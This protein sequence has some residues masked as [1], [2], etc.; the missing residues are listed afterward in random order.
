MAVEIKEWATT[1]AKL[2]AAWDQETSEPK[3]SVSCQYITPP[4]QH[5][6][7]GHNTATGGPTSRAMLNFRKR[8]NEEL[9]EKKKL[10]VYLSL[11]HGG[12]KPC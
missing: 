11:Q 12:F 6:R 5:L 9:E 10:A 4:I 3:P 7:S 2:K 8:I 1:A